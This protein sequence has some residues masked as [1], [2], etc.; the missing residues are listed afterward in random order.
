[1][2][3][4]QHG[5]AAGLFFAFFDAGVGL[6]GPLAGA[7]AGATSGSGALL[8]VAPAVALAAPIALLG[9]SRLPLGALVD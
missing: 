5:A 1:V 2:S 8:T 3:P 6:G 9:R 7:A 4:E